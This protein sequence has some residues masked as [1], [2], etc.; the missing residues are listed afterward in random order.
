[1]SGDQANTPVLLFHVAAGEISP[2]LRP[3][4]D[5]PE[6]PCRSLPRLVPESPQQAGFG[7]PRAGRGQTHAV[8]IPPCLPSSPVKSLHGSPGAGRVLG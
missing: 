7:T 6:Q 5:A 2:V 3:G 4:R 8:S 1:M